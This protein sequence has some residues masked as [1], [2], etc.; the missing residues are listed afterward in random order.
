VYCCEA[1][2]NSADGFVFS[3]LGSVCEGC[4]STG[5][6]QSGIITPAATGFTTGHHVIVGNRCEGNAGFG[7]QTDD[8]SSSSTWYV[9]DV[10]LSGNLFRGNGA[11]AMLIAAAINFVITG[12]LCLNSVSNSGP[13]GIQ[14]TG[15][16]GDG[17][18]TDVT[19]V[20]NVCRGNSNYGIIVSASPGATH[21]RITISGNVCD[22][23]FHGIYATTVDSTSAIQSLA[24]T[25]NIAENN[26]NGVFLVDAGTFKGLNVS[27]NVSRNNSSLDIRCTVGGAKLRANSYGIAP[28]FATD[29][30]YPTFASDSAA[31]SGGLF[32][33]EE[34]I[35][36]SGAMFVK[37]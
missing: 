24:I 14:I 15:K 30:P 27:S 8:F 6:V 12:N 26:T 35:N 13:S 3:A 23:N 25:G 9:Q 10:V 36:S 20:G 5:N 21:S 37:L 29:V 34:Y 17:S 2:N 4:I 18:C 1:I 19:V 16:N 32:K 28:L 31:G 22:A 11:G 7:Y 33:G